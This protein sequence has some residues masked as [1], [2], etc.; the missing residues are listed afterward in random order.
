MSLKFLL[1]RLISSP[2]GAEC[3][4]LALLGQVTAMMTTSANFVIAV[5]VFLIFRDPFRHSSTRNLPH[6]L[7]FVVLITTTSAI[8][9]AAAGAYGRS[10]DGTCWV[11]DGS[12]YGYRCEIAFYSII[13]IYVGFCF[14]VL[15]LFALRH[16]EG[17]GAFAKCGWSKLR[18]RFGGGI[19]F[20]R[21]VSMGG[22]S[23]SMSRRPAA[24]RGSTISEP[25]RAALVNR[26]ALFTAGF[27]IVWVPETVYF[28]Y[29]H[30]HGSTAGIDNLGRVVAVTIPL[31]GFVNLV[32]W[33]HPL[34]A[35]AAASQRRVRTSDG[36]SGCPPCVGWCTRGSARAA[37]GSPMPSS[38]GDAT[39]DRNR[40]ASSAPLKQQELRLE[41]NPGAPRLP[42]PAAGAHSSSGSSATDE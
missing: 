22:A 41:E 40:T 42:T 10:L 21:S 13:C 35:L 33:R 12:K 18:E 17:T 36:R 11:D 39:V 4:A 3:Y 29:R 7:G 24:R 16:G 23:M 2:S 26:M 28:L 8:A 19:S 14:C 20:L 1:S 31:T 37:A 34:F 25:D 6:Y 5:D 30:A 15:I 27:L 9:F 38:A 32:I